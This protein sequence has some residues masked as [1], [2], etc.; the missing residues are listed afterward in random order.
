MVDAEAVGD[1]AGRAGQSGGVEQ[2]EELLITGVLVHKVG[3]REV[4][5]G[6]FRGP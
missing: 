2:A 3:D 5:R 1:L 4:H 6:V